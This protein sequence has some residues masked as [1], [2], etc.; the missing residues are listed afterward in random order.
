MKDVIIRFETN[1]S[2]KCLW[3]E[4][5]DLNAIGRLQVFRASTI[6]YDNARRR[7]IVTVDEQELFGHASRQACIDF[8]HDELNRALTEGRI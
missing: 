4:A 3:T 6:E 8:E 7:W 1:G 2:A 5:I